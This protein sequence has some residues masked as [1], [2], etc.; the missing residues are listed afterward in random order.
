M[1]ELPE[2]TKLS[3]PEILPAN[4][5][6]SVVVKNAPDWPVTVPPM[7]GSWLELERPRTVWFFVPRSRTALG[8]LRATNGRPIA[9]AVADTA[10]VLSRPEFRRS[11]PLLMATVPVKNPVMAPSSIVPPLSRTKPPVAAGTS[12]AFTA[13]VAPGRTWK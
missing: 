8:P 1:V 7:P 13:S 11:V 12:E 9:P 5:L 3:P 6:L 10:R 4:V 2:R